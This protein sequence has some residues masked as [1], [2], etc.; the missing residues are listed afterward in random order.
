MPAHGVSGDALKELWRFYGGQLAIEREHQHAPYEHKDC[1]R[2]NEARYQH[3][4]E[5]KRA[6]WALQRIHK[7]VAPGVKEV[8]KD[9]CSHLEQGMTPAQAKAYLDDLQ[10]EIANAYDYY[11][12]NPYQEW[13]SDDLDHSIMARDAF[14]RDLDDP[15]VTAAFVPGRARAVLYEG[16]REAILAGL[17]R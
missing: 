2:C 5:A 12:Q 16:E 13:N 15:A 17:K 4:L 10:S 14:V 1:M 3:K 6:D 7:V 11:R 8:C 9:G